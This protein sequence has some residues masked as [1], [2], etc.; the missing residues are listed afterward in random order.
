MS[1]ML[2]ITHNVHEACG[3][4]VKRVQADIDVNIYDY[5]FHKV[6]PH[7]HG[8]RQAIIT[9]F[10]Q[11]F[12]DECQKQK[13]QAVWD[14]DNVRGEHLVKILNQLNFNGEPP[15]KVRKKKHE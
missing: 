3:K 5:F 6:I 9:H 4:K 11:R 14:V 2:N 10:F 7:E 1:D 12:Y 13:I 15:K 8:S